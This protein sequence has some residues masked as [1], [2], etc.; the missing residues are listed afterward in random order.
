[1]SNLEAF[2]AAKA[3]SGEV[4]CYTENQVLRAY[5]W[6]DET[7]EAIHWYFEDLRL[8]TDDVFIESESNEDLLEQ[9][10][11][12]YLKYLAETKLVDAL[13]GA[14]T[15]AK[16]DQATLVSELRGYIDHLENYVSLKD[17]EKYSQNIE[18]DCDS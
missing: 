14:R 17:L 9:V 1:M 12:M 2:L 7:V 11:G 3:G 18:I 10:G 16:V 6:S 13:V 15:K 8:R 4:E 5:N